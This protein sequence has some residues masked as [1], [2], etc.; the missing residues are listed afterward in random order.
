MQEM[1]RED[2]I[3][4]A[5]PPRFVAPQALRSYV[6]AD[7][8]AAGGV[9][10]AGEGFVDSHRYVLGVAEACRSMGVE[11]VSGSGPVRLHRRGS[12][13]ERIETNAGTFAVD[14]VVVAAGV[15]SRGLAAQ[16]GARLPVIGGT[17]YHAEFTMDSLDATCPIYLPEAHLVLT[18]LE[19]RARVS[20]MLDLG[21][22]AVPVRTRLQG[23]LNGIRTFFPGLVA[24]PGAVWSGQRPC[25]PDSL[26]IVG[27]SRGVENLWYATGHG[28]MGIALA[29]ITGRWVADMVTGNG[30]GAPQ[31]FGPDRFGFWNKG[32]DRHG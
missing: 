13:V 20:G 12:R 7:V 31:E 5:L 21:T 18:P 23:V 2:A 8:T 11:V 28:M 1:S 16:V 3:R 9:Y 30:V 29:P 15:G 25:T 32:G 24:Q 19:G 26:P 17:G 6:G 27:T 10:T 14:S 22:P 4:V